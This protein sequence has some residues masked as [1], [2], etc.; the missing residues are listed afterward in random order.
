VLPHQLK[1]SAAPEIKGQQARYHVPWL[2]EG[3][4]KSLLG[5]KK[6]SSL[7][8]ASRLG[9]SEYSIVTASLEGIAQFNVPSFKSQPPAP[10]VKARR[11][12]RPAVSKILWRNNVPELIQCARA[13]KIFATNR[14]SPSLIRSG[15][16]LAALVAA[17]VA[18]PRLVLT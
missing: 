13:P 1:V 11:P 10:C 2:I 4:S 6:Q 7:G 16:L 17:R 5:A 9:F 3:V 15:L 14:Q 12:V 8:A 18:R